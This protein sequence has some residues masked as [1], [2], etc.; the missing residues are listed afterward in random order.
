MSELPEGWV[1][2]SLK[3]V[4]LDYQ[5]GFASGK[6]DIQNGL[7]HL[8]MNNITTGGKLNLDLL[9]KVPP[10]L[11]N[12]KH[13]LHKGDVIV[14]TT[15]S[16]QLVG[17]CALFDLDGDFAFSNHLTRLRPEPQVVISKF[18]LHYLWLLWKQGHFENKCKHWVNQSTLPKEELLNTQISLPPLAEQRR[19]V[20]KLEKLLSHVDVAQARLAKI[21]NILKR[22]RQSVLS[23]AS[24][25]RLTADWR[26]R[27][28]SDVENAKDFV[29]KLNKTRKIK[30]D[31]TLEKAAAGKV[32]KPR[33]SN[34]SSFVPVIDDGVDHIPNGWCVT[35]IGDV[36]ECLD[37][38]RIPIN[39]A[40]R[41]KRPGTIP[42]YGANGQVGWIDDYLFDE[43]LVLVVEDETF[44]GRE[45]PFSYT[46]HG[47]SWVNNHAHVLRPCGEIS[48]A[49]LNIC[50]SYYDFTPLT[51]GTTG[52]R[53]LN[54]ETLLDASFSLAPLVEQQEIVRRVE[55]LFKTV[56]AIEV[57][58]VK[59]KS[60]V[61]GLAQSILACAFRGEL[62]P[63]DPNDESAARACNASK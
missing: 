2:C 47:K 32:R 43:D 22:L 63:Q 54:Q 61:D 26:I 37:S 62:V 8:R 55:A 36:S 57:N 18:L 60:H 21:P 17:K 52:R 40:E 34:H 50:W 44:V 14:C 30:Y 48:A 5:S 24:S 58:Y 10:D 3:E 28:N 7:I 4:L 31:L 53:K 51:S 45:K 6:K 42:Y 1:M 20:A 11:A 29:T 13:F 49:Y 23:A 19:I 16:G 38:L 27:I 15:N 9:R 33:S 35:R 56:D 12:S 39:K 41:L 46:I 59:V 25:G